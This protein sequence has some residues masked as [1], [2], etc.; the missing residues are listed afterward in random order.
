MA[1]LFYYAT[2]VVAILISARILSV[3]LRVKRTIPFKRLQLSKLQKLNEKGGENNALVIGGQGLL[4]KKLVQSLVK[5][6][7][8]TIHSLDLYIPSESSRL[9]GVASY[10]QTDITN[11]KDVLKALEGMDSVFLTASLQPSVKFSDNQMRRVN[12]DGTRNVVNACKAQG[13]K[14]LIY[15]SSTSVTM[16]KFPDKPDDLIQESDPF[17]EIPLNAYV[18]SK[19]KA[20]L[21]VREADGSGQLNTIAL[22]LAGLLGG[23]SNPVSEFF[24]KPIVIYAGDGN[25]KIDYVHIDSAV[26]AHVLAEKKLNNE[27]KKGGG[28]QRT[29]ENGVTSGTH[30]NGHVKI[31]T[32]S[33]KVYMITMREKCTLKELMEHVSKIRGIPRPFGIPLSLLFPITRL[34]RWLYVVTGLAIL[35][36]CTMHIE[37]M[38]DFNALPDLANKELGWV[39]ETS[40]REIMEKAIHEY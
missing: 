21:M 6:G 17:P 37:F 29:H 9:Q 5:D 39:D 32:I 3:L 1:Y 38:R 13:V 20:E 40:W 19:G 25:F 27:Q 26:E 8:Y 11:E 15:T 14:R 10:I 35:P 31:N 30:K 22:R 24:C 2:A 4:G 18:E 16:S 23:K 36:V 7:S 33:G 12:I 34:N 28:V